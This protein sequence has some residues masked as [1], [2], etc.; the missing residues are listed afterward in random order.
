M[1]SWTE[2]EAK[3]LLSLTEEKR[4]PEKI[5]SKKQRLQVLFQGLEESLKETK[6]N[7]SW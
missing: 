5:D 4:I 6:I 3:A 7:Y 1:K 2:L